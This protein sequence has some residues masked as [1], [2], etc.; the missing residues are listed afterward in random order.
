MTNGLQYEY[1]QPI[2][3]SLIDL[4]HSSLVIRLFVN[5]FLTSFSA[6]PLHF[7]ISVRLWAEGYFLNF[8][9]IITN[10]FLS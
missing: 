7:H 3:N 8:A 5:F 10:T 1:L 4:A 6:F 2:R 9:N